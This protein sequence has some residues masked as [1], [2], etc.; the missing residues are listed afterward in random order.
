MNPKLQC[1]GIILPFRHFVR[2]PIVPVNYAPKRHGC[3]IEEI[4]DL[5]MP[6]TVCAP[7]GVQP[8][9]IDVQPSLKREHVER[10]V[11]CAQSC[12][13]K[14]R[15]YPIVGIF[16]TSVPVFNQNPSIAGKL[17]SRS[18]GPGTYLD[19]SLDTGFYWL[20]LNV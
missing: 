12:G 10:C 2:S 17:F 11:S 16:A 1:V 13:V 20:L 4:V 19:I 15:R 8:N 14:F 5:W 3:H 9:P 7:H 18:R 6:K